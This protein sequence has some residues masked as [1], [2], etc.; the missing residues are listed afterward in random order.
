MMFLG[1]DIFQSAH[2]EDSLISKNDYRYKQLLFWDTPEETH[3]HNSFLFEKKIMKTKTNLERMI[4]LGPLCLK[5]S[6]NT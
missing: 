3:V 2:K 6:V 4:I 5:Q 1:F